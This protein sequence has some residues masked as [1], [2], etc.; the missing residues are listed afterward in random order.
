MTQN[1]IVRY[2]GIAIAFLALTVGAYAANHVALLPG[3]ATLNVA[4][5]TTTVT[6]DAFCNMN[7]CNITWIMVTSNTNV[8]SISTT[9]GAQTTFTVGTTP[10]TAYIIASDGNGH[11]GQAIVTVQ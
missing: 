11:T 1:K 4:G 9:S 7:P 2:A 6:F 5:P 8:G 3:T 10:G